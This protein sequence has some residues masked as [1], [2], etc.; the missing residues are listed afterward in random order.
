MLGRNPPIRWRAAYT[1]TT[2]NLKFVGSCRMQ[3]EWR[4]IKRE[5]DKEE[6]GNESERKRKRANVRLG[7]YNREWK[8]EQN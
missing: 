5:R 3:R 1:T 6:G 7:E 2:P 8:G 4:G